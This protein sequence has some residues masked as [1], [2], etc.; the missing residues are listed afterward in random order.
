M[1]GEDWRGSDAR[2]RYT[3]RRSAGS[4]TEPLC[5]AANRLIGP[6]TR[7]MAALVVSDDPW[8]RSC[9]AYAIGALGLKA[10]AHELER[11][12]DADDVLLRETARQAKDQLAAIG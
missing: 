8:L 4:K 6:P 1:E 9:A 12:L 2:S 5:V 7:L 3:A 11:W 10:L